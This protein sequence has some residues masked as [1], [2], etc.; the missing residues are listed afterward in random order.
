[1]RFKKSIIAALLVMA[2]LGSVVTPASAAGT[3]YVGTT[4]ENEAVTYDS[5][6]AAIQNASAGDTIEVSSGTYEESID[7]TTNNVSIEL[8]SGE[9]SGTVEINATDEIYGDALYGEHS[10]NVT[11][12]SSVETVENTVT[13]D[14]EDTSSTGVYGSVQNAVNNSVA[15]TTIEIAPGE[16][17]ESVNV[18]AENLGFV[19]N[20]PSTGDVTINATD[21]TT[22]QAFTGEYSDNTRIGAYVTVEESVI[23]IGGGAIGDAVSYDVF[24][25]PAWAIA[26]VAVLLAYVYY[27]ETN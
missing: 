17:S 18:T 19:N 9:T 10:H 11:L 12:G 23:G 16:Y 20:A 5:I 24:G 3:L 26:I 22:G 21:T 15:N 6:D 4:G 1:M 27:E 25:I 8:Y 7:V 13:V 2:M 14:P